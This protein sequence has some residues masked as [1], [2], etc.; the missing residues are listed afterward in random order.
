MIK[1]ELSD[2]LGI[3][4]PIIQAG[5]G[6][7][8]D[9][10]ELA[11][12]VSNAGGIGIISTFQYDLLQSGVDVK[13]GVRKCIQKVKNN[14]DKNFG[15]NCPVARE[16][17]IAPAVLDAVVE[18]RS[19]DPEVAKRLKVVI[20][21]AGDPTKYVKKLKDTGVIHIHVVPSVY[22][23]NKVESAGVDMV[24]ASGHEAGG[25]VNPRPVHTMVLL[26]ALKK[27]VKIPVIAAGGICDGATFAAAL[28]LGAVGVQIGTRFIATRES[29]FHLKYKESVIKAT[30][31][32]T[33]VTRG[34]FGPCRYLM[35]EF[36]T[37]L[38]KMELEGAS[39]EELLA[40]EW[41]GI[42]EL[43]TGKIDKAPCPCGEVAGRID[44]ILTVRELMDGIVNEAE[45]IIRKLPA[46]TLV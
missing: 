13:E 15:I 45:E 26:P 41:K 35:N 24:V 10:T 19:R 27:A 9:T 18:E 32:D 36:S 7:Y 33:L 30:E 37:M 5:M 12:A 8:Y 42:T 38:R 39:N 1:T 11:A 3:K 4:Y 22:H 16:N 28:L 17:L 44:K 21:S 6:P 43:R 14:T 25:H 46:K 40:E 34:V 20:T 31:R 29:D 23:A 2:L